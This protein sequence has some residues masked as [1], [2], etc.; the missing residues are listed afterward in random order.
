M[1]RTAY[2]PSRRKRMR[3][4]VWT[5]DSSF[6]T[7]EQDRVQDIREIWSARRQPTLSKGSVK[8]GSSE[9]KPCA[10]MWKYPGCSSGIDCD[11]CHLCPIGEK[12]RRKAKFRRMIHKASRDGSGWKGVPR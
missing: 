7:L 6:L 12:Q 3:S 8:H 9:C 4:K 10:W 11:F 2:R 5:Q 1:G